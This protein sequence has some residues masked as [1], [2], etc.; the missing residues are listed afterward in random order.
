MNSFLMRSFIGLSVLITLHNEQ[1]VEGIIEAVDEASNLILLSDA[2]I[3]FAVNP[4]LIISCARCFGKGCC[5]NALPEARI[6]W[7]TNILH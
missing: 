4:L 7:R 1:S 3:V 2:G 5:S 6:D